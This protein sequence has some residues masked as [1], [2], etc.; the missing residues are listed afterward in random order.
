MIKTGKNNQEISSSKKLL[1]FLNEFLDKVDDV[2]ALDN[3][4]LFIP[5]VALSRILAIDHIYKKI[6]SNSGIIL[7]FGSRFGG[8]LALFNNLRGIYEPFNYT[9]KIVGFDTFSGFPE[10][11]AIDNTA[12]NDYNVPD[13][14]ERFL[15]GILEIHEANSPVNH[16]KKNLLLK[17]D[18]NQTLPQ[19]FSDNSRNLA[20]VYF[21]MDL[22]APTL[23]C[24]KL[25]Q[26]FLSKGSILVFDDFNNE[27]FKGESKAVLD[28]Y[29]NFNRF[30]F[31]NLPFY[32]RLTYIEIE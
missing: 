1:I 10:V 9:R 17:G 6:L 16:I 18:V 5:R 28:Y 4:H 7:E 13:D 29:G 23:E 27:N 11:S 2:E 20:L 26:P 30:K 8:N 14:H 32:S 3:L 21:D 25:I 15:A 19:F 31:E 24:L 22:Y 12:S